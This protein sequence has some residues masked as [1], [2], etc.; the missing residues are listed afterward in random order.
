[1]EF[2]ATYFDMT[3]TN[4]DENMS[5]ALKKISWQNTMFYLTIFYLTLFYCTLIIILSSIC[6]IFISI[7]QSNWMLNVEFCIKR[8]LTKFFPDH[9]L[10]GFLTF[11]LH[12]TLDGV[13]IRNFG[14]MAMKNWIEM[15]WKVTSHFKP[16]L[17]KLA[18]IWPLDFGCMSKNMHSER[19]LGG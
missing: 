11:S 16:F 2:S 6:E 7:I 9:Y 13:Y 17:T 19:L 15:F 1:M 18:F 14:I 10:I 12:L 5:I 8:Q 4:W 3:Q